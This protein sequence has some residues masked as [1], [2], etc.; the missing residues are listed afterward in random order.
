[1]GDILEHEGKGAILKKDRK[2]LEWARHG[3]YKGN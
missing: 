1:M 3:G 2:K